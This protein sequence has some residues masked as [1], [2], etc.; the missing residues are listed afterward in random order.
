MSSSVVN[1]AYIWRISIGIGG[2]ELGIRVSFTFVK[3]MNTAVGGEWASESGQSRVCT[4]DTIVINVV[5]VW[6]SSSI[7]VA[8]DV[9][10]ISFGFT[11]AKAVVNWSVDSRVYH[12]LSI[13]LDRDSSSGGISSWG[14]VDSFGDWRSN[15][16]SIWK[17]S[18]LGI[19][20][21]L[22]KV[23]LVLSGFNRDSVTTGSL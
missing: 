6:K 22:Q 14:T 11:L 12:L 17:E 18:L 4:I 20:G 15:N 23:V 21:S 13:G 9:L 8:E 5:V 19:F 3:M 10:G 16:T 1:V 7:G 2:V